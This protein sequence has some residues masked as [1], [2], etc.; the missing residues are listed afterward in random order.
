MPTTENESQAPRDPLGRHHL[1]L[2]VSRLRS[3]L[4]QKAKQEP[5]FRFYA[6]YDRIY[7]MDVLQ[8]AWKEVR[9]TKTA[10]GVDGVTFV[11]IENSEEGVL[12]FLKRLHLQRRSQRGCRP[13]HGRTLYEH[14][15]HHLGLRS[16]RGRRGAC[17]G[18][19]TKRLREAGCGKSARPV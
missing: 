4:S 2:K 1:P 16:L 13:P 6:L 10:P 11:D 3:K 9:K 19:R 5:K 17:V 14:L 12:G 15:Y 18:R 8:A 7:R